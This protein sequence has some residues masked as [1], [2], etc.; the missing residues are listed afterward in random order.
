[1]NNL[2]EIISY[3]TKNHKDITLM[4]YY[5]SRMFTH[6]DKFLLRVVPIDNDT[7]LYLEYGSEEMTTYKDTDFGKFLMETIN[8]WNDFKNV[9]SHEEYVRLLWSKK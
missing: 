3:I 2:A 4:Y 1:M 6:N 8:N 9:I 7:G 5:E